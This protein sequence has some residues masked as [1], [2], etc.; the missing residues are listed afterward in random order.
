MSQDSDDDDDDEQPPKM[1][2]VYNSS[3]NKDSDDELD[4]APGRPRPPLI[5]RTDDNEDTILVEDVLENDEALE[6]IMEEHDIIQEPQGRGMRTRRP[7][8][9]SYQATFWNQSYPGSL[10][11]QIPVHHYGRDPIT[12]GFK[13]FHEGTALLNVHAGAGCQAK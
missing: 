5:R 3:D 10:F 12:R 8:S 11:R 6:D 13:K 1:E 7:P 2:V 4:D 9:D